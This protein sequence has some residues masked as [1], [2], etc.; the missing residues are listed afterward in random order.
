M[1]VELLRIEDVPAWFRH[2]DR[3][4]FLAD[5]K[6]P[7]N[8]EAMSVWFGRYGAGEAN[9]WIVTYD[10]VIVVLKGRFTVRGEDGTRTAGPS[11]VI[12]L[13]RGT[14]VTY[15]A[16]EDTELVGV[17]FPHWQ[18]AQRRSRHAAMLDDLQPA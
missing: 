2:T 16:E 10:E 18:D 4:I 11:E 8:S 3:Q 14:K 1:S 9:D 13:T 12:F 15:A 7:S 5:V 17:T 6:D